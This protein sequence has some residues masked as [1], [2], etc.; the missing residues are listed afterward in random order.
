MTSRRVALLSALY[1]VFSGL[2][3]NVMLAVSG[4]AHV[5]GGVSFWTF[6]VCTTLGFFVI[7]RLTFAYAWNCRAE[8]F[9]PVRASREL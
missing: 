3:M 9:V 6:P 1:G 8:R 4:A 5:G 7:Y 2:F